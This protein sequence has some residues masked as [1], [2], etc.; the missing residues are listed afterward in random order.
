[1]LRTLS[2]YRPRLMRFVF[3]GQPL[4]RRA[5]AVAVAIGPA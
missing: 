1:V 2:A 5:L 4:E 3:D